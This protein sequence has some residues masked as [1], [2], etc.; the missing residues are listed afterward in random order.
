M[1]AFI[2]CYP[3]IRVRI[4]A[5]AAGAIA[6]DADTYQPV[7]CVMCQQVH[8]VNPLTGKLLGEQQKDIFVKP[9]ARR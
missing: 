1:A 6:D 7:A 4:Q 5:M 8:L 3:N 2:Y 9:A